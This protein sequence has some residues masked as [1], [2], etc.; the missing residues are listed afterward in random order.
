MSGAAA[1][2]WPRIS[3]VVPSYNQ[4]EF[5][6]E[7]L[8]SLI[9]QEYPDLEIIVIDGGSSDGSL[10][11]IERYAAQLAWWISEPDKGQTDAL[12]KG[13]ARSNATL[14]LG[15]KDPSG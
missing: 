5:L 2:P 1:A 4:A 12:I 8:D 7:T 14:G 3:I 10:A 9:A 6:G 15:W 13:F 11:V